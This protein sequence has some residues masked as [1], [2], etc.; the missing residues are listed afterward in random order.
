MPPPEPQVSPALSLKSDLDFFLSYQITLREREEVLSII[1]LALKAERL[2]T[3]ESD[4]VK[5]MC[6]ELESLHAHK[7]LGSSGIE[8]IRA[9]DSL[10]QK[11]KS[12]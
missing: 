3:L 2:R 4:V 12:K 8:A 6:S 5:N 1:S 9:Y 11:E 10:I 7:E